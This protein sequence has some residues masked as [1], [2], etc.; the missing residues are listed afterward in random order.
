MNDKP[1]LIKDI[2]DGKKKGIIFLT[3]EDM[4]K[5]MDYTPLMPDLINFDKLK[6]LPTFKIKAYKDSVYRGE[7][8]DSKRHGQGV[9]VYTSSRVYE[10]EWVND[11]RHG[12]GFE[13]FSNGNTYFGTYQDGRVWGQ[14][15]YTW[16]SGEYFDGEWVAGHKEG[17]GVW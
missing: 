9:I 16:T 10:G 5:Y 12:T 1:P 17:Y 4:N 2:N 3:E 8:S 6:V 15:K 14:G 7:I 13:R 11:K